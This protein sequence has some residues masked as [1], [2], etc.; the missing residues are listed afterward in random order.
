MVATVLVL[1]YPTYTI[2]VESTLIAAEA[3]IT[4]IAA[5]NIAVEIELCCS[6]INCLSMYILWVHLRAWAAGGR[7]MYSVPW[8]MKQ[9][10]KTKVHSQ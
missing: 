10:M 8:N 4:A 9:K 5:L 3:V 6:Y 2:L 7:V 1:V